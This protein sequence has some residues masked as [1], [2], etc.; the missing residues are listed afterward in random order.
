[1]ATFEAF[2]G[3]RDEE[4]TSKIKLFGDH[5]QVLEQ[6]LPFDD[7]Y[8]SKDV[9][10]APIR[11]MQLIYN[12]GVL[13]QNLPFDDSYKSKDVIAA[14]I[15]V[16]QLIYN[17]G[18][19]EQNLPFDDSYK[20]KDVI[21]APIRVMQLIYNAGVLFIVCPLYLVWMKTNLYPMVGD[22]T[23]GM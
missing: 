9:I 8:K 17:A 6:N 22:V 11:V 23:N 16:M 15:R 19:L 2:I 10:A 13:E 14:P 18:V 5:L 1:M 21:A 4:E 7:S 20:S 3:I 12:A